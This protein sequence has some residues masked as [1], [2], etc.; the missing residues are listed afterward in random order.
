MIFSLFK[1]RVINAVYS[2]INLLCTRACILVFVLLVREFDE[3]LWP[4]IACQ[5]YFTLVVCVKKNFP[6]WN[7]YKNKIS[8]ARAAHIHGSTE[9]GTFV[10][11]KQNVVQSF[12]PFNFKDNWLRQFSRTSMY[13]RIKCNSNA[14]YRLLLLRVLIPYI[15]SNT[16]CRIILKFIYTILKSYL[17]INI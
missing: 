16:L 3:C 1:Q 8:H 9:N 4:Y 11:A 17:F 6:P 13:A 10:C 12:P 7:E 14:L 15:V 2:S 5:F